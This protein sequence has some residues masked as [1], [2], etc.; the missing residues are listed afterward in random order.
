MRKVCISLAMVVLVILGTNLAITQYKRT[1]L[2]ADQT[3]QAAY[4]GPLV[5][6]AQETE[7]KFPI[8]DV[9]TTTSPAAMVSLTLCVRRSD[10]S[11]YPSS[12]T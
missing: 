10:R 8:L 4:T 11:A 5:V 6:S 9:T 3:G 7:Y 1:N 2:V 12:S